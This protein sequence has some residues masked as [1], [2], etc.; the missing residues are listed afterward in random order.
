MKY[1][2]RIFDGNKNELY[3]FNYLFEQGDAGDSSAFLSPTHIFLVRQAN[4]A[5][6]DEFS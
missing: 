2:Q 6:N 5:N 3:L 4:G 1:L